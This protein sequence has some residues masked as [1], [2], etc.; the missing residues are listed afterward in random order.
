MATIKTQ[1]VAKNIGIKGWSV[2]VPKT[3][4]EQT[5][6]EQFD[7]VSAGKYTKGLGQDRMAFAGPAEDIVSM[8]MTATQQLID[9]AGLNV[10]DVGR[11]EVGTET[12]VDKSK[13]TKTSL[14][15]LFGENSDIEGIDTYNACFGGTSALFNCLHWMSSPAWDG[16]Y[17]I[18]V[19]GDIAV[20]ENG[21]AR[22]AGGAG[23]VALLIGPDAPVR[24][25]LARPQATHMENAYDFYKP[26]LSSEYP[27]VDGHLSNSCYLR[28]LDKCFHRLADKNQR[29][30]GRFD[31]RSFD[32]FIFHQPYQK[33]VQKSY[34]RLLFNQHKRTGDVSTDLNPFV[35]IPAEET[36]ANRELEKTLKEVVHDYK[37]KVYPGT[38][39]GRE[40]GNLY[41]GSLWG[42][43]VSLIT[44]HREGVAGQKALM[45][46]YGS[47]LAAKMFEVSFGTDKKA[48]GELADMAD[49]PGLFASREAVSPTQFSA[50]LKEREQ[51]YGAFPTQPPAPQGALRAGS[52]YLQQVDAVGRRAY[53]RAFSTSRVYPRGHHVHGTKLGATPQSLRSQAGRAMR[54]FAKWAL[55]K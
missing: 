7:G 33:L 16:R 8:M 43:L 34:A 39:L 50:T 37:E 44:A 35:E 2:Y 38:Y 51:H 5:E 3:Y 6:L 13:S 25:D 42:G 17:G 21:P 41:T 45:F 11:L 12:L 31:V 29:A 40:A 4:V 9:K 46:S 32:H 24:L 23:V 30:N 28:A 27:V 48:L 26:S 1:R 49:L 47:G 22:P 20:Y 18:V 10:N 36:Y 19:T 55:T 54:H 52:F 14:M 53:A 15:P